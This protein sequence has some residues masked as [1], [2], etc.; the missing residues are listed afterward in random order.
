MSNSTLPTIGILGDG[1]LAM[2]MAE[3]YQKLGGKVAVLGSSKDAPA[4]RTANRFVIG[5]TKSFECLTDFFASVDVVTLEN[6]FIDSGLLIEVAEQSGTGLFPDPHRYGLIEDK[7]SE[8]IF[9]DELGIPIAEYFEVRDQQDLLDQPGYLKLAKGGYDGIGT[10]KVNNRIEAADIFNKIKPSGIVLF[11]HKMNFVKELSLIAV[12]NSSELIFYPLVETHQEEGTCRYVTY[13]AG[14]TATVE[15]LAQE[16]VAKIIR[17]LDTRGLFAF[18]LFLTA[19]NQLYLNESAPRP[20]NSGHITL[21]LMDCSQFENHMRAIA[22]LPL[23]KPQ[24]Q[25]ESATMVNLLGTR[26]G[27]LNHQDIEAQLDQKDMTIKLYGKKESRIKRKM[28]HINLWGE[29]QWQRAQDIVKNL[30]V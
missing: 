13:P 18:E 30:V 11:E 25:L 10:Y 5:D 1:Q 29:Q 15:Q 9:F 12:S 24:A 4:Y 26:N 3:A 28:G 8:N 23:V 2:M 16:M 19:D 6:E 17:K 21:D 22:D 27:L 7:L 20:H 14:V